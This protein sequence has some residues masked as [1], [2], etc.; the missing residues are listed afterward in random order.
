TEVTVPKAFLQAHATKDGV[1]ARLHVLEGC[2]TFFDDVTGAQSL[3]PPGIRAGIRQT[4]N[5]WVSG[6]RQCLHPL[7]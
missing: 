1:W 6:L 4:L 2:L 3:L 5:V 7:D